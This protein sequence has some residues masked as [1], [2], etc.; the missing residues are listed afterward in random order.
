MGKIVFRDNF[1]YAVSLNTGQVMRYD[2]TTGAPRPAAGN[3]GA[4]FTS[5]GL[6]APVVPAFGPDGHLY[7]AD[8]A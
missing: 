1:L 7:V 8:R 3:S 5:G 4:V 6:S 2:A